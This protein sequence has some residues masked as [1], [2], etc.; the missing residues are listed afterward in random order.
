MNVFPNILVKNQNFKKFRHSFVDEAP[1]RSGVVVT[2]TAQP[3]STKP[4]S[5]PFQIL[6]AAFQRFAIVMVRISDNGLSWK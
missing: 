2:T 1:W 6:L 3:Y 4:S 5:A